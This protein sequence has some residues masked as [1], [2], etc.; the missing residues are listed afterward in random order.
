VG[1]AAAAFAAVSADPIPANSVAAVVT[2]SGTAT[3][4]DICNL[5]DKVKFRRVNQ[6]SAA[7]NPNAVAN[8]RRHI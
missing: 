7:T 8:T 3:T 6:H 1:S 2:N 5:P 4:N